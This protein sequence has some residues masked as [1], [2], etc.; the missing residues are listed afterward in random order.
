MQTRLVRV[1]N[2]ELPIRNLPLEH[3]ALFCALFFAII[4]HTNRA[5]LVIYSIIK[6]LNVFLASRRLSNI[7]LDMSN[8]SG[9]NA[10][11]RGLVKQ[12]C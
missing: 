5:F 4:E 7:S 10:M 1:P 6:Q 8:Q 9:E 12:V 11:K 2:V 3:V